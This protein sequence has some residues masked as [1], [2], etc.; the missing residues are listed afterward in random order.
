MRP[1]VC[2]ALLL[3]AASFVPAAGAHHPRL[4]LLGESIGPVR[5]GM[6]ERAVVRT[7]GAPRTLRNTSYG[8]KPLRVARYT[9]HG[10]LFEVVYDRRARTV[11]GI[12]TASRYFRTAGGLGRGSPISKARTLR[13]RFSQCTAN[14]E[15]N[16]RGALVSFLAGGDRIESVYM[17]RPAY[18]SC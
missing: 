5:L 1:G 4:I 3:A 13:F 17:I 6:S 8:G 2:L 18:T 15:K 14:W 11:V 12:G 7:L 10:G 16:V 9:V